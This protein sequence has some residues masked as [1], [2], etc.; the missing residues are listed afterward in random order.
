MKRT[1]VSL[2]DG[3]TLAIN[4][5]KLFFLKGTFDV[6]R[7]PVYSVLVDHADGLFVMDTGFDLEF[8]EKYTP[9]DNPRQT[10]EQNLPAQ[11]ALLGLRP[12][13]VTHVINTHLHIDHC[14]GNKHFPE[15]EVVVHETEYKEAKDPHPFEYQSYSDLSFDPE[16]HRLNVTGAR[17]IFHRAGTADAEPANPNS[18]RYR[19]LKGDVEFAEGVWLYETPGHSAGH[20]SMLVELEGRKPMFFTADASYMP[21]S[22]EE[23]IV[24]GYHLDPVKAYDSLER[25]KKIQE[26]HDAELFFPHPPADSMTYRPA[27]YWYE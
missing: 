7:F 13:D 10:V 20:M 9:Q 2:L 4:S 16:L 27:P 26:E 21:R 3:G 22:L 18:P 24:G 11:L 15:A 6:I 8:M 23:M 1:R 17:D 14:G 19:L 5:F 25:L 12:E